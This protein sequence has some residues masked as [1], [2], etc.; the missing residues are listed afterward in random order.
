MT[1]DSFLLKMKKDETKEASWTFMKDSARRLNQ[2]CYQW[3]LNKEAESNTLHW[4][5]SDDELNSGQ[6]SPIIV[7]P[8]A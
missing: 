6:G 8:S 4:S 5:S 7:N 3:N 1:T 2:F